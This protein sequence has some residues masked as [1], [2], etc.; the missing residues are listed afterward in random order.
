MRKILLRGWVPPDPALPTQNGKGCAPESLFENY[1]SATARKGAKMLVVAESRSYMFSRT[2]SG[3]S[4]RNASDIN[5]L[6]DS[7]K[8]EEDTPSSINNFIYED[9]EDLNSAG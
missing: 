2:C 6:K 7:I 1:I 4:L 3:R 5:L 8:H 9:I